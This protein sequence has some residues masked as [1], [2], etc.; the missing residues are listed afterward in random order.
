LSLNQNLGIK[1]TK[2]VKALFEDN[3]LLIKKVNNF[4]FKSIKDI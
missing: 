2:S 3:W 4:Y 1:V